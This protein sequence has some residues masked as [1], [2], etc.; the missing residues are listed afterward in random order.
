[1]SASVP[2]GSVFSIATTYDSAITFTVASNANPTQLTATDHGLANGDIVEVTS[3]WLGINERVARVASVAANTFTLEGIDTSNTTK[4][5]VG[6]GIGSVRKVATWTQVGQITGSNSSGGEQQY[7][8]WVYLE[9]GRQ[10]RRPTFKN[11]KTLVLTM[12]D[13]PTLAWNAVLQAA[14]EDGTARA[15]RLAL[16]SGGAIYYNTYVSFDGEPTLSANE[17]MSVTA[18]FSQVAALKRYAT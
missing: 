14:D 13:D 6:T 11:A 1:M 8:E 12:A 10:R 17:I 18:S 3:G 5:P 4:Y 9:D 7:V 15:L 2:N 16:A